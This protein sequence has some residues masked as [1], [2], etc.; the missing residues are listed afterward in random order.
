MDKQ[1]PWVNRRTGK[2]EYH[3]GIPENLQDFLPN[4]KPKQHT[5][6]IIRLQDPIGKLVVNLTNPT[7][8]DVARWRTAGYVFA[9]QKQE[10]RYRRLERL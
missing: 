10:D 5:P 7:P 9:D 2:T 3:A 8:N 1:I 4:S 6:T